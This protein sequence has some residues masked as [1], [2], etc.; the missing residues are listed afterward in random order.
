VANAYTAGSH[1][2]M[3][4]I[5]SIIIQSH[6]SASRTFK[7]LS[8]CQP[9][10]ASVRMMTIARLPRRPRSSIWPSYS[11]V[12]FWARYRI[13]VLRQRSFRTDRPA[14]SLFWEKE[15]ARC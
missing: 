6:V 10:C 5:P 15:D 4:T 1:A 13:Q 8:H 3:G 9:G 11:V 14:A 12:V 7:F 2:E